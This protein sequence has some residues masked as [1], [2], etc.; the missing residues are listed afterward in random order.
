MET[1]ARH[2]TKVILKNIRREGGNGA[3]T[4]ND[5]RV[6]RKEEGVSRIHRYLKFL[7]WLPVYFV[8]RL[9]GIYSSLLFPSKVYGVIATGE[10]TT[11]RIDRAERISTSALQK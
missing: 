10:L 9:L 7:C 5:E 3:N 2:G 11:I 6:L 8:T 4:L 1:A